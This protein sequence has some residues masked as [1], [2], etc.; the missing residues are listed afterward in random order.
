MIEKIKNWLGIK[1]CE[2]KWM[3]CE[4]IKY[5]NE[6]GSVYFFIKTCSVCGKTVFF[7]NLTYFVPNKRYY[8]DFEEY[9][10]Y[11]YQSMIKEINIIKGIKKQNPEYYVI[12]VDNNA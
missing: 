6:K 10:K 11:K 8:I 5:F 7:S 3:V 2:H 9:L 12:G 1:T 4:K